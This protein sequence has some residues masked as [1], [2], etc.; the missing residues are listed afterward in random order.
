MNN[1]NSYIR[2]RSGKDAILNPNLT[3]FAAAV[4]GVVIAIRWAAY[5]DERDV[6]VRGCLNAPNQQY[7]GPEQ[8]KREE[9]VSEPREE[10]PGIHVPG[11]D[12]REVPHKARVRDQQLGE[13]ER[14]E[15][16]QAQGYREA[17]EGDLAL[18]C[19]HVAH[20]HQAE[21]DARVSDGVRRL[22]LADAAVLYPYVIDA[23]GCE[24]GYDEED[25][26]YLE[27]RDCAERLL[28]G[29][30]GP[31]R[32]HVEHDVQQV[33]VREDG[34][35]PAPVLLFFDECA[36]ADCYAVHGV[37]PHDPV[38]IQCDAHASNKCRPWG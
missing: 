18:L 28:Y 30:Q 31:Q 16:R 20:G 29:A 11:D 19:G 14:A 2:R 10:P 34:C 17:K 8:R 21:D 1:L 15:R 27:V 24:D 37:F 13:E 25:V 33:Q 22:V 38:D 23:H 12:P 36:V 3:E 26:R 35:D 6:K 5:L 7:R 4:F 9:V 32:A